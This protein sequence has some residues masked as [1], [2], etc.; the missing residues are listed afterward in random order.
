MTRKIH[1]DHLYLMFQK[2]LMNLMFQKNLMSL[3]FRTL[4]R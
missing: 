1:P 3:L 4:L 2:N